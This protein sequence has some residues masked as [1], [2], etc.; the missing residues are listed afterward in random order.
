MRQFP[1]LSSLARFFLAVFRQYNQNRCP[2]RAAGLAYSTL[3]A[4]VPLFT[5]LLGFGG[6]MIGSERVQSFLA[7]TLLPT[8]QET[9]LSAIGDFALNSSRLGTMGLLFFLITVIMLLNNIEIHLST[10]FRIRS[11]R[12]LLV[13]FT[14]YTAVL[15]FAGLFLGASITFSG[16]LFNKMMALYGT[17]EISSAAIRRISSFLFIFLTELL[18]ILLMPSGKVRLKSALIGALTGSIL[19]E[20]TKILFS[21]WANQ[22]V[23]ISVIYGSLFLLPLLLIWLYT[24]W[25]LILLA[26]EVTY[27]HQNREFCSA[28]R[29]ES[30][31]PGAFLRDG[32]RLYSAVAL[33]FMEGDEPP[34]LPDLSKRLNLPNEEIRELLDPLL[35]NRMIHR[36]RL[37]SRQEG[38]VP[39]CPPDRQPLREILDVLIYGMK[40]G[41]PSFRRGEENRILRSLDTALGEAVGETTA[42]EILYR[43]D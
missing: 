8:R 3:L 35:E 40:E 6:S 30:R 32:I 41:A 34:R 14:T 27:V 33:P 17:G 39:S 42:G 24:A 10:I 26:V 29:S 20:A 28:L 16:S 19:W 31:P 5:I 4:V 13:R 1:L 11:D 18:L 7:E 15:V 2:Q 21:A 38:F 9:I 12:T 43:H 37:G 23:R 22:S 25:L 36:V